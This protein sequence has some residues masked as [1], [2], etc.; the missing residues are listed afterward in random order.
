MPVRQVDYEIGKYGRQIG[1]CLNEVVA[2]INRGA[3]EFD[4]AQKSQGS[5]NVTMGA[6]PYQQITTPWQ[7]YYNYAP[8]FFWNVDNEKL[9][10][11]EEA[12][13]QRLGRVADDK[14]REIDQLMGHMS[15]QLKERFPQLAG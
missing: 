1:D 10:I 3:A 7:R 14:F 13:F 4:E 15:R 6:I 2:A 5:D 8:Y 11:L 12:I 9:R